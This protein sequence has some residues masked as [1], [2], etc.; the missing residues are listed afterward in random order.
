[1]KPFVL[2]MIFFPLNKQDVR[3]PKIVVLEINLLSQ[4]VTVFV[5]DALSVEFCVPKKRYPR[6]I[7]VHVSCQNVSW[8]SVFSWMA[9]RDTP[10]SSCCF[11]IVEKPLEQESVTWNS[12]VV[13]KPNITSVSST[14]NR[15]FRI[16]G[17]DKK[18]SGCGH[19]Y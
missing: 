10:P 15:C 5:H 1:M 18:N 13:L 9:M 2:K 12:P 6:W 11:V 19:S 3:F 8:I 4:F 14:E 7:L 17:I 16:S